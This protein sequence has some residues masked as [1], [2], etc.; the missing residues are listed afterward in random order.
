MT[1]QDIDFDEDTPENRITVKI[2]DFGIPPTDFSIN[3][4][5][6]D[7]LYK[8]GMQC[9]VDYLKNQNII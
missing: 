1:A 3:P 4:E 6:E 9:T 8:S 7:N 2:D 5:E